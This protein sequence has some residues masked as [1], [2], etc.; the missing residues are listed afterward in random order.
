MVSIS[1]YF[2]N[3]FRK[4]ARSSGVKNIRSVKN[5]KNQPTVESIQVLLSHYHIFL[6]YIDL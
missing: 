6:L 3:I 4:S 1:I 5:L 2:C